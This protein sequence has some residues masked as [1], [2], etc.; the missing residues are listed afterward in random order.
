MTIETLKEA[1]V[2]PGII[3]SAPSP[4]LDLK[5][6]YE[7]ET[8]E[9]G[10]SIPRQETTTQ[11][12]VLRINAA[13]GNDKFNK[14][15]IIMTDPDLFVK[16]DPTGQVRVSLAIESPEKGQCTNATSSTGCKQ[17]SADKQMAHLPLKRSQ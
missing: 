7:N 9:L 12:P 5:V 10:A 14:F 11:T 1:G 17:A 4:D 2:I 16:N 8:L 13:D 3:K 15:T 6:S